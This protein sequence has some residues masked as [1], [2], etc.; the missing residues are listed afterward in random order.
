MKSWPVPIVMWRLGRKD[1]KKMNTATGAVGVK[2]SIFESTVPL[3][4]SLLER[5]ALSAQVAQ[6]AELANRLIVER[7]GHGRESGA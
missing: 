3:K 4:N 2:I 6:G 5:K 7:A 1:T